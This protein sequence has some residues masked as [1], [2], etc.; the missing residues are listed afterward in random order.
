MNVINEKSGTIMAPLFS[1]I[2]GEMGIG[3]T[4]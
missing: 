1:V 4:D 2:I 3:L